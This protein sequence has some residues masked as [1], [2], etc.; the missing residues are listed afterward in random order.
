[1]SETEI[2]VME[3]KVRESP[4]E[5]DWARAIR[6]RQWALLERIAEH[7]PLWVCWWDKFGR[8]TRTEERPDDLEVLD[9][10]SSIELGMWIGERGPHADWI[11]EGPWSEERCAAPVRITA[12]GRAALETRDRFDMEPVYGGFVEPGWVCIPTPPTAHL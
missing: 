1:M 9:V 6:D 3:P 12:A 2:R 5:R 4:R 7:D 10:I 11:E 8:H